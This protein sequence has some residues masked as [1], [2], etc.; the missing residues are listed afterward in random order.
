MKRTS[1]RRI[2][3]RLPSTSASQPAVG[4]ARRA[5][6]EVADV[7]RDMWRVVKGTLLLERSVPIE[8]RV[9]EMTPVLHEV[10]S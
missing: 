2:H 1:A 9:E 10:G 5:K 3:V 4:E 6:K 8:T 7:M